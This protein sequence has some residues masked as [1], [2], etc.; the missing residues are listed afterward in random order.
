MLSFLPLSHLLLLLPTA[1]AESCHQDKIIPNHDI[2]WKPCEFKSVSS[3]IS[4]GSLVV[5]LDYSDPCSNKTI[6]LKLLKVHA[7][8]EPSKGS[9]LFNFGGPGVPMH[10]HL[11]GRSET[12]LNLTGGYHNLVTFDPRDKERKSALEKNPF[13]S[14]NSSDVARGRIWADSGILAETCRK[15]QNKTGRYGKHRM[16]LQPRYSP[17][18]I[19]AGSSYGTVLGATVAAMFPKKM[20]KVVLDAVS[21]PY[22]WYANR[23]ANSYVDADKAFSGFCAYCAAVPK[24][25][26]L[27]KDNMT[28]SE[29]EAKVYSLFETLKYSP[30]SVPSSSGG[31]VIN[32]S[33]A[34]RWMHS[35]LYSPER[36]VYMV[37]LLHALLTRDV[38]TL[39]SIDKQ[40]VA[41][42]TTPFTDDEAV[43]GIKCSDTFGQTS[44]MN[45]IL[46]I[47]H[48]RLNSSRFSGD[49]GDF[50]LMVCAQ[51]KLPA[52]ERYNGDFRVKTKNPMLII[53]TMYDPVT[54]LVS[55]RN[56]SETFEGS[57]LLQQ[58]SYG[59]SLLA[60]ASLC[61][62]KAIRAYFVND[63]LP[64]PN[65]ICSTDVAPFSD[66]PGWK[67]VFDQMMLT[68]N[69]EV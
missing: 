38:K 44:D 18:L 14:G 16:I 35:L 41:S 24:Q 50:M 39:D 32:Y 13:L 37:L 36:W 66:S 2:A 62:A 65:T 60:Q 61:T 69:D 52:K 9:I 1:F 54:P 58:D 23:D 4:C 19:I 51:W 33:K 57:V 63:K 3:E 53:N 68:G 31:L 43:V 22:D 7:V 25:C 45:D 8:R 10:K 6:E 67:E 21:N 59:H 40:M 49:I 28:A 30:I 11:V 55:A 15:D 64:S 27:G 29:L 20:G 12:M 48:E 17:N 47:A 42:K 26:A 5:P 46:P 34:K 56:V